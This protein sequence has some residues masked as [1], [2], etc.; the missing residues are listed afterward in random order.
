MMRHNVETVTSRPNLYSLHHWVTPLLE[1]SYLIYAGQSHLV[2]DGNEEAADEDQG[3]SAT[4][5]P[6][7]GVEEAVVGNFSR[8]A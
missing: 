1:G 5:H 3:E 2:E 6:S 8:D 4:H 7:H